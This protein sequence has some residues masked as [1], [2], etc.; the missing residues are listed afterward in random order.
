MTDDALDI[1]GTDSES[2]AQGSEDYT[3]AAQTT[4]ADAL[5]DR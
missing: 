2:A 1:C 4:S 5:T 3:S